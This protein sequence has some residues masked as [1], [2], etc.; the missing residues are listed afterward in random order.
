VT[1][2]HSNRTLREFVELLQEHEVALVADV[3][4]LRGS[5][6]MPHF[7]ERPLRTALEKAEIG[8]LAL[9]PL[10]GRRGRSAEPALRPCWKNRGF[11]NYADHMRTDEFR[12]GIRELLLC[13]RRGRTAVMC[14][15]AVPWRCHRSLIGDYLTI[16]KRR[17]V[18]ELVGDRLRPH[19]RTVCARVKEGHLSYDLP[20]DGDQSP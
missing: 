20:D 9:P 13:A 5:R 15:E 3:R 16:E 14:A 4:K 2:G 8:Y 12:D 17:R 19:R 1:V 18:D 7:N 6:A 10:A 11:R